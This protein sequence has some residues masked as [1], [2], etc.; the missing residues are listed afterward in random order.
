M[1]AMTVSHRWSIVS[2]VLQ[3]ISSR[4]TTALYS[5]GIMSRPAFIQ[6]LL[7][8]PLPPLTPAGL[9]DK[10]NPPYSTAIQNQIADLKCHPLLESVVGLPGL[11]GAWSATDWYA[12]A[13]TRIRGAPMREDAQ[14][15]RT[16]WRYGGMAIRGRI[17]RAIVQRRVGGF[18]LIPAASHERRLVLGAL[19]SAQDAGG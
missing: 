11:L 2:K 16:A 8:R 1:T 17:R 10:S 19:S 9:S 13:G 15:R 3:L 5:S 7:D 12:G 4:R 6:T 18:T 14:P